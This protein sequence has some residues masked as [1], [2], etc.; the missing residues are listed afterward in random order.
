MPALWRKEGVLTKGLFHRCEGLAV[1]SAIQPKLLQTEK[2][3]ARLSKGIDAHIVLP[4]LA[5]NLTRTPLVS[6]S[7]IRYKGELPS[8]FS[9]S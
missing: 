5:A 9:S 3:L 6:V 4:A 2:Q 1:V 8:R 7:K